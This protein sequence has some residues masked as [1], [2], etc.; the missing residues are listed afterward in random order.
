M[1]LLLGG[2]PVTQSRQ[3]PTAQE[4]AGK[5]VNLIKTWEMLPPTVNYSNKKD[6]KI[7]LE[8]DVELYFVAKT[9]KGFATQCSPFTITIII[10][11]NF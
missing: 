10:I 6:R 11:Q 3:H 4:I 7:Y 1:C 8:I 2:A 9:A 5:I